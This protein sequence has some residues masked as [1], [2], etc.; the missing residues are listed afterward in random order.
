M[1]TYKSDQG[2]YV[3]RVSAIGFGLLIAM[4]AVWLWEKLEQGNVGDLDPIYIAAGGCI[5]FVTILAAITARLLYFSKKTGDFLI[6]TE[7][8]MK[9]V[10]WSSQEEITRMTIVVI[11][12]TL[13]IAVITYFFDQLFALIFISSG[14]LDTGGT[15]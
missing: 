3:R 6:A 4:G 10:N 8:E 11:L 12:L 2:Y 15:I 5:I 14:V 1:Q 7:L 13:L 9:K